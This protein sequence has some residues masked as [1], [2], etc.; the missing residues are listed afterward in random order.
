[1]TTS[2]LSLCTAKCSVMSECYGVSLHTSDEDCR[3]YKRFGDPSF[4]TGTRVWKKNL[5]CHLH[6]D[7]LSALDLC[8]QWYGSDSSTARSWSDAK[9]FCP[10]EDSRLI[11]LNTYTTFNGVRTHLIASGDGLFFWVGGHKVGATWQWIDGTPMDLSSTFWGPS[12]PSGASHELFLAWNIAVH[13]RFDDSGGIAA[14]RFI[15]EKP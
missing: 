8:F 7:Y 11:V 4:A 6:Y 2:S 3:G 10:E 14:T 9:D 12:E 5:R 15:C 13:G 1:M